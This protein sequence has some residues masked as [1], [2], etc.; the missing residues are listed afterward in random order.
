MRA[1][2]GRSTVRLPDGLDAACLRGLDAS[3]TRLQLILA[4]ARRL[5]G[6]ATRGGQYCHHPRLSL[7]IRSE[8]QVS[9][10][11]HPHSAD[12]ISNVTES[13]FCEPATR[14]IDSV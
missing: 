13:D 11:E 2:S 5:T 4:R 14:Q 6:V 1:A 3:S 12:R 8:Q 10:A 7:T 9:A